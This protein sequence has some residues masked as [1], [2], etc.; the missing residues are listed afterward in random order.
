MPKGAVVPVPLICTLS[1]G[2][3]LYLKAQESKENFLERTRQALLDL[4]PLHDG[5]GVWN[6]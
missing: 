3:P 6:E 4:E 5:E 1:F 2:E